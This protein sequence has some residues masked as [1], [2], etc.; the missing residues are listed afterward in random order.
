MIENRFLSSSGS[1]HVPYEARVRPRPIYF[2]VFVKPAI[3][4]RKQ[5]KANKVTYQSPTNNLAIYRIH[6]IIYDINYSFSYISMYN[7]YYSSHQVNEKGKKR[8]EGI[9]RIY[10]RLSTLGPIEYYQSYDRIR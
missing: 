3:K 7:L 1:I 4:K 2:E 9:Y 5:R 8:N 6:I 10:E